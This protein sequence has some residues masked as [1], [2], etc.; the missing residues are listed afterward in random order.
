MLIEPRRG[1]RAERLAASLTDVAQMADNV[2]N[3]H[4]PSITG[5]DAYLRWATE[6]ERLLRP[7][8]AADD[9]HTVLLT[10]RYWATS[11]NPT[12]TPALLGAVRQEVDAS[13]R[14]L[15][16]LVADVE[17]ECRRWTKA[18]PDAAFVVA[19]TN[20]YLHHPD[21]LVKIDWRDVIGHQDLSMTMVRL[22]VPI[23]VVDELDNNKRGALRSR[24]RTTIKALYAA[25]GTDPS[26]SWTIEKRTSE[27]GGIVAQ[28]RMDRPGH[29]RFDRADDELVDRALVLRDFANNDVHLVAY[30]NGAAFRSRAQ[31][32]ITHRLQHGHD[33]KLVPRLGFW[34]SQ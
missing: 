22:V 2:F 32:L 10:P 17:R 24:A 33:G 18:S 23:L 15:H 20:V 26:Q 29:R 11:A 8:L 1:V 16:E 25:F 14:L 31:G 12:Q 3:A 30:D 13:S 19:D 27:T 7:V 21:E 9:L 5:L 28:L 6:A 34:Q 4:G